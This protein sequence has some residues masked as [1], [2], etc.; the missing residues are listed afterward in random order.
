[1]VN[2]TWNSYYSNQHLLSHDLEFRMADIFSQP[3]LIV[4]SSWLIHQG[5]H[6]LQTSIN[7]HMIINFTWNISYCEMIIEGLI[8]QPVHIVT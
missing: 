4:R 6:F 2:S 8:F 7:C 1:M 5:I 3:V